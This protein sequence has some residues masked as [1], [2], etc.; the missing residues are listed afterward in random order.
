VTDLVKIE[1]LKLLTVIL[2][3]DHTILVGAH[4]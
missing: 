3:R 2:T 4:E 1:A